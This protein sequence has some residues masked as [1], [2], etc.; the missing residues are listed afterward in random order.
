MSDRYNDD[1]IRITRVS[2][3]YDS[4]ERQERSYQRSRRQVRR[5]KQNNSAR[6]IFVVPIIYVYISNKIH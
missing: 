3:D 6:M 1:D 4:G 2:R 5:R